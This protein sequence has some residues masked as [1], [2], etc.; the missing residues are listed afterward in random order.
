MHQFIGHCLI[1]LDPCF[2]HHTCVKFAP[3]QINRSISAGLEPVLS[4]TYILSL[5]YAGSKNNS[6][7]YITQQL[8]AKYKCY[9]KECKIFGTTPLQ[10]LVSCCFVV[11]GSIATTILH[12]V[13][14]VKK[15]HCNLDSFQRI[16]K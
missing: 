7:N 3:L 11:D 15:S 5:L 8:K 13:A 10:H 12:I 6:Y 4:H 16:L 9:I 1:P 14:H 2:F